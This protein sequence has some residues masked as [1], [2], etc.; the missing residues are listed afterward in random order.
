MYWRIIAWR[1]WEDDGYGV[2]D[3][4]GD[5]LVFMGLGLSDCQWDQTLPLFSR[6]ANSMD[7]IV[8]FCPE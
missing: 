1:S 5:S 7:F 4:G 3:G 2:V 6:E 8:E